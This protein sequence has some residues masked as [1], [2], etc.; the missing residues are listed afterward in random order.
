[1]A[2]DP[3]YAKELTLK[4]S[5]NP[6]NSEVNLQITSNDNTTP[7]NVKVFDGNGR[8]VTMHKPLPTAR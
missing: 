1:M 7:V 6:S 4:V 5:P 2:D 3:V 8:I